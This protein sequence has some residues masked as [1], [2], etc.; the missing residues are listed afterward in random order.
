MEPFRIVAV[1]DRSE[2]SEIVLEHALDHARRHPAPEIHFLT[3]LEDPHASIDDA[4]ER[5]TAEVLEDV[6][7][8]QRLHPDW[9]GH[10]HV[11]YGWPDHEIP[12]FARHIGAN[13]IVMGANEDVAKIVKTAPCPLLIVTLEEPGLETGTCPDCAVVRSE[14]GGERMFCEFHSND[15]LSMRLPSGTMFTGAPVLW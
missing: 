6:E 7:L 11:Q 3:I 8:F 14:T 2:L 1:L 5:M 9:S 15:R 12:A 13:L 10:I 4:K